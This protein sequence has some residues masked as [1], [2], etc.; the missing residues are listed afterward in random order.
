[1]ALED[2]VDLARGAV[3]T[4][5][6]V[7]VKREDEQAFAELNAANPIFSRMRRGSSARRCGRM[8]GS[9]TSGGRKPS[10]VVAQP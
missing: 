2:L 1:M 6:Q 3:V 9:A 5:T 4:E 8:A 7:M 10:G